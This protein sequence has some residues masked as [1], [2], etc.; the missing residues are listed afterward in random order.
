MSLISFPSLKFLPLPKILSSSRIGTA[1]KFYHKFSYRM[2]LDHGNNLLGYLLPCLSLISPCDGVE[3]LRARVISF[4]GG[5]LS[6]I[7]RRFGRC[8]PTTESL[9]CS[10]LIRPQ[11]HP[12]FL[13]HSLRSLAAWC[14]G[15]EERSASG[16]RTRTLFGPLLPRLDWFLPSSYQKQSVIRVGECA[17]FRR[18]SW[19]YTAAARPSAFFSSPFFILSFL[20]PRTSLPPR[21]EKGGRG[22]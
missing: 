14:G 3:L 17:N 2:G 8:P 22:G 7:E 9:P 6:H 11:I 18:A 19:L 4:R 1:P 16:V 20:A 5:I 10:F 13:A 15:G 21:T 12:S